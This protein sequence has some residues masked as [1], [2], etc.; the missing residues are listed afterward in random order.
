MGSACS[1]YKE[2]CR[3]LCSAIL[4][5]ASH[6]VDPKWQQEQNARKIGGRLGDGSPENLHI[7]V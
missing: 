1:V 3:R 6:H 4:A 2:L 5:H 7:H